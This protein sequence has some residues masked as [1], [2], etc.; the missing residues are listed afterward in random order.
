MSLFWV[1]LIPSGTAVCTASYTLYM[2]QCM[3]NNCSKYSKCEIIEG[4]ALS[5]HLVS[6]QHDAW[7]VINLVFSFP[8][9]A[10]KSTG[11]DIPVR[12]KNIML[13]VLPLFP[14][15]YYTLSS[16]SPSS[17]ARDSPV[18]APPPPWAS[19]CN[20]VSQ[21]SFTLDFVIIL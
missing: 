13:L 18:T 10:N 6:A 11:K 16:R 21:V 14:L 9:P 1:T 4:K 2:L 19:S 17:S 12:H 3:T 15:Q 20:P 7:H 8:P 5:V